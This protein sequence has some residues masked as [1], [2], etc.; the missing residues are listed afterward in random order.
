MP[1]R[2]FVPALDCQLFDCTASR[3]FSLVPFQASLP[4]FRWAAFIGDDGNTFI[5]QPN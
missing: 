3:P 5:F 2:I 4:C 1:T